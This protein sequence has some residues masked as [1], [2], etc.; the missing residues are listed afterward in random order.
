MAELDESAGSLV[1]M[2]VARDPIFGPRC[3]VCGRES[4]R[5]F[6]RTPPGRWVRCRGCGLVR[7]EEPPSVSV[8]QSS[9][10]F[11]A[12]HDEETPAETWNEIEPDP[13]SHFKYWMVWNV[14]SA[15]GLSGR[16]ID[17]GCGNGL[18]Q[19]YLRSRGWTETV[20][21]EPSGN[22]TGR[23]RLGLAVYNEPLEVFIRRPEMIHAF[24]VAV[25]NHVL[26]HCYDPPA[27]LLRVR[28]LLRPGGHLFLA[29]PNIHG[30]AM[31]WKTLASRSRLKERPF[32]HLDFPKH[33]VLFH[34]GNLRRLV[35]DAGLLVRTVETYTRFSTDSSAEPVRAV[36]WDR[37]GLGDNMFL[38]AQTPE[39][40]NAEKE[41]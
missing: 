19:A 16:L 27:F 31:R 20:G 3:F 40:E 1:P 15:H 38:V 4:F 34:R 9:Y 14:L 28:R 12:A 36:G 25:A 7:Q 18:L 30:A 29:T 17:V 10:G 41:R 32:R 6:A 39:G 2:E 13:H 33:L 24:D 22:P 26:E 35:A 11:S 23:V 5:L 37:L 21:V 8:T